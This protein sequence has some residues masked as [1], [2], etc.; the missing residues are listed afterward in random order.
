MSKHSDQLSR[1]VLDLELVLRGA[2]NR[3][4]DIALS[5]AEQWSC[6][7]SW[8]LNEE[9]GGSGGSTFDAAED[10]DKRKVIARATDA[11]ASIPR[12]IREI[13]ESARR[14]RYEVAFLTAASDPSKL[15]A[16]EKSCRSC[17]REGELGKSKIGGHWSTP[18]DVPR[19][20]EHD[21]CRWCFEIW[22]AT[23]QLPPLEAVELRHSQSPRAAGL[24]MARL[25]QRKTA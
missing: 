11:Q 20:V 21:L 17:R 6:S 13:E 14:L 3:P 12:L 5:R 24:W 1:A 8:L 19:A 15:P 25:Q 23:G 2:T 18:W 9:K 4:L 16:E 7:G 10:R 22:E